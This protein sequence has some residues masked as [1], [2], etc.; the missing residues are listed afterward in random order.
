MR[1][2][3]NH[4]AAPAAPPEAFSPGTRLQHARLKYYYLATLIAPFVLSLMSIAVPGLR[5][6]FGVLTLVI[7]F[8]G[9]IAYCA[10]VHETW[11]LLPPQRRGSTSAG[12]A[13]GYHF[14]P[15]FNVWWTFALNQRLAQGLAAALGKYRTRVSAPTILAWLTPALVLF[16]PFLVMVSLLGS[17]A[18]GAA[19][20]PPSTVTMLLPFVAISPF[21]WFAWMVRVDSCNQEILFQRAEKR[22]AKRKEKRKSARP[23]AEDVSFDRAS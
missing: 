12:A 20:G 3:P 1:D 6:L 16:G 22:A 15:F 8:L 18:P 14:I 21:V 19:A 5:A 7:V 4:Y 11:S 23:P 17:R 10:W 13:V 9:M 2:Q